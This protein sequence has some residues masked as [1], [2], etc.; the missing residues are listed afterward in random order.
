MVDSGGL[1]PVVTQNNVT[2]VIVCIGQTYFLRSEMLLGWNL[3]EMIWGCQ[4]R[5]HVRVY[6]CDWL[7]VVLFHV[8]AGAHTYIL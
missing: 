1:L 7:R 6:M 3:L 8:C 5:L 4:P 2:C